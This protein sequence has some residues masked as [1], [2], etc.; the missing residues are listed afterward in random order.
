M[1]TLNPRLSVVVT[2]HQRGLLSALGAHQGRSAASYLRMILD[3]ATPHLAA[4]LAA[5][6][7]AAKST[8][9]L[10]TLMAS[11]SEEISKR[12]EPFEE[13]NAHQLDLISDILERAGLDDMAIAV[14][15][16]I[17]R[18]RSE[19]GS[20]AAIVSEGSSRPPY[21]NTGVR[22]PTAGGKGRKSAISAKA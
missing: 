4:L 8:D 19:G 2:P 6:D 18:E 12:M 10:P 20:G 11:V 7:H 15:D 13:A 3:S 14:A 17:P 5:L 21:C 1:P 22:K 9:D 16:M